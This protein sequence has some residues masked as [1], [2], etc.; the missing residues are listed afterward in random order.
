MVQGERYRLAADDIEAVYRAGELRSLDVEF[1]STIHDDTPAG[2]VELASPD[3]PA[4][5]RVGLENF[6]VLTR[7]NR[8]TFYAA[9]VLELAQ[10]VKAPYQ[11]SLRGK[12]TK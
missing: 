1:D 3:V 12:A 11:A 10:A 9:A 2:L 5:Y 4:E 6:Y 7:Y 8:S